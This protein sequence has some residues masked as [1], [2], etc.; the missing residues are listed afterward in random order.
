MKLRKI[1]SLLLSAFTLCSLTGC[2]F[3]KGIFNQDSTSEEVI[4]YTEYKLVNDGNSEYKIVLPNEPSYDEEI[5]ALE[6]EELFAEATSVTLE[7]I[8]ESDVNYSDTAKLIVLGDTQYTQHTGVNVSTIPS[9]GFTVKTVGANLF[10]LGNGSGVVYGVYEFLEKAFGFEYY[11]AD[12]YALN[13]NVKNQYMPKLDISETP[14]VEY[15]ADA[16]GVEKSEQG[17]YRARLRPFQ[18]TFMSHGMYHIHNTFEWLPKDTYENAH[19][20]WYSEDGTQLCYTAHGDVNELADMQEQVLEKFKEQVNH[21]FGKG[22]Y[23]KAISFTQ[24]DSTTGSWCDCNACVKDMQTYGAASSSLIRFLNPIA[25]EFKAWLAKTY[26]GHEVTIVF[27]AYQA[28]EKAPVKEQNGE[29]VPADSSLVLEDNLA[30]WIAPIYG[31]YIRSI[32]D[33]QNA[34]MYN[35]FKNWSVLVKQFYVW[36]Y[37]TNFRNYLMWYDTFNALPDFYQYVTQ[38]NVKYMF[39]QGQLYAYSNLTGFDALKVA[40][41]YKLMWDAD[42]DV[43]RFTDRFFDVWFGD[44]SKDMRTYYDSFI[45]WSDKIKKEQ[46]YNGNIYFEGYTKLHYPIEELNKWLSNVENAY[47]SIEGL[48]ASK[49]TNYQKYYN[50]VLAESIAIRY[51]LI[52][53]HSTAYNPNELSKMK[54]SFKEDTLKLGFTQFSER[55]TMDVLYSALGV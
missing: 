48:K 18:D 19:P 40:L 34:N 15:R 55:S 43:K 10:V 27:F 49:P 53:L 16:W 38:F 26:P 14:D 4:E 47:K 39:N 36:G 45:N 11:V 22:D 46:Y 32:S 54:Q 17:T 9:D 2:S 23:R 51:A 13:K 21:Y 24:Q 12:V 5:A 29:I 7:T 35:L 44:A 25:K 31:D 42:T 20:D 1:V 8:Y 6:V 50:R 41:N 37:D 30:A 3:I 28:S 52:T 33:V